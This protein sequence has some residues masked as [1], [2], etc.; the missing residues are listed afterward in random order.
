MAKQKHEEH[1]NHE[2]WLVSYADFITLLFA[3][4]VVMYSISSVNVGKYRTVSESIKAA[5]NPIVTPPSSPSAFSLNANKP[6]LTAPNTPGSRE[7]AM[8]RLR[9]LVQVIKGV[10]QMSLVRIVEQV[11][12]DIV[13]VIPDQLLFNSGEAAVRPEAL[14][15]LEGLGAAILELDRHTRVEGHTDNV[16]IR[17][18]QFPS[19]W[20]LSAARA[21]MVVRVLSELYGVPAGRLAAVGHADTRPITANADAEQ[22]AK[23]RRVEVVILEQAP[24]AP[25]IQ[26]ET[27]SD[28]FGRSTGDEPVN[29]SQFVPELSGVGRS[30]TP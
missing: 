3:F 17:T 1:E 13:I 27:D 8:R 28:V 9:N 10:P 20:E 11:N 25:M 2:R 22:R 26:T 19:N 6:A 30:P 14:R 4:F 15:F 7:V 23:N 16:P 12:G 5:L 18:A 29:A 24:P 21:V